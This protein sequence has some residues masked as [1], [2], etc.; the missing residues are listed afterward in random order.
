MMWHKHFDN[1][2]AISAATARRHEAGL[3]VG[4]DPWRLFVWP[5]SDITYILET[6]VLGIKERWSFWKIPTRP[7]VGYPF[8]R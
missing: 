5:A 4:P 2:A 6:P 7:P 8:L 1:H 3:T